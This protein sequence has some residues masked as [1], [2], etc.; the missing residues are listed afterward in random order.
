V[1]QTRVT[2]LD[3]AVA[4]LKACREYLAQADGY[5]TR[6]RQSLPDATLLARPC[7]SIIEVRIVA[8]LDEPAFVAARIEDRDAPNEIRR[9]RYFD[10]W[11][12]VVM[13]LLVLAG[14]RFRFDRSKYAAY[15]FLAYAGPIRKN[16]NHALRRI[17]K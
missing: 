4:I 16:G 11:Y 2:D 12:F 6:V 13:L 10:A 9:E 8:P 14:G 17:E 3:H 5:L 15:Y 7:G 1:S